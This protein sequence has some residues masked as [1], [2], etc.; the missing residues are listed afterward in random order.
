MSGGH[1]SGKKHIGIS[2][3]KII[4]VVAKKKGSVLLLCCNG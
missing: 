1:V 3:E 2:V 4:S